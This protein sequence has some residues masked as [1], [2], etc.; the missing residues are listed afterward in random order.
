MNLHHWYPMQRP[1]SVPKHRGCVIG[2]LKP[3]KPTHSRCRFVLLWRGSSTFLLPANPSYCTL[4]LPHSGVCGR[5]AVAMD[6]GKLLVKVEKCHVLFKLKAGEIGSIII[7]SRDAQ[8]CLG[9]NTLYARTQQVSW[10]R[11]NQTS[12]EV[13]SNCFTMLQGTKHSHHVQFSLHNYPWLS[14]LSQLLS[15]TTKV[16]DQMQFTLGRFLRYVQRHLKIRCWQITSCEEL[17]PR[18]WEWETQCEGRPTGGV[19]CDNSTCCFSMWLCSTDQYIVVAWTLAEGT[20]W[21]RVSASLRSSLPFW[22]L[23]AN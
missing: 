18:Q 17:Q 1:Q 14:T 10:Q 8:C 12:T 16:P 7:T 22:W 23:A 19:I 15:L 2:P 9:E 13:T 11:C 21:T 5:V 4:I 6:K 3:W 20:L